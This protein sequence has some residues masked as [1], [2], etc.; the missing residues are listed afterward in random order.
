[1]SKETTTVAVAVVA[2]ILT[3]ALISVA[4]WLLMVV[5]GALGFTSLGYWWFLGVFA[6]LN[7]VRSFFLRSKT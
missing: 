1:M 3:V 4:A 6:L 5:V 2:M 7:V